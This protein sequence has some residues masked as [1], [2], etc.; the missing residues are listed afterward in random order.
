VARYDLD[1]PA[2]AEVLG[3]EPPYRRRQV[4]AGLWRRGVG[5]EEMTDLPSSLRARLV[6]DPR[7]SSS[8]EL[9]HVASSGVGLTEKLLWQL[10]DGRSVE[11]VLIRHHNRTT[12]CVS[13]QAGCAMGCV[14]CATGQRGFGRHLRSAEIVEQA[15]LARRRAREQGWPATTNVV[16]MGMGEPLANLRGVLGALG[17]LTAEAAFPPRR[18]VVSTVGIPAGI[19]RLATAASGVGL[20]LSLHAARDELRRELVPIA[21]RWPLDT[22][23]AAVEAWQEATGRRVSLEWTLIEGVNDQDRDADELA[24]I[25][26]RLSAFVNLIPLNPTDG[27]DGRPSAAQTQERFRQRLSEAGV[28]VALRQPRGR[29]VD[30]ACGQLAG[31]LLPGSKAPRSGVRRLEPTCGTLSVLTQ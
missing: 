2:L 1:E 15:V 3:G 22:V 12:I 30:A 21:R 4:L 13:S 24:R 23:L 19:R 26:S 17:R 31:R 8:L 25:A 18:I 27:F 14:F 5:P 7:L 11:T 9:R 28:R 6:T 10:D 20:A 16:F 29:S